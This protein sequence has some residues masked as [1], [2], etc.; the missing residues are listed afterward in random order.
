MSE[1]QIKDLKKEAKDYV[2]QLYINHRQDDVDAWDRIIDTVWDQI[3][4]M[5][6]QHCRDN[7]HE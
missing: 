1:E 7:H 2:R 6:A 5:V 3:D 4:L